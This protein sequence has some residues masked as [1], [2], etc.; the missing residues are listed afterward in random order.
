MPALSYK[1]SVQLKSRP[2]KNEI[3]H[4]MNKEPLYCLV[5]II[6]TLFAFQ[7]CTD[8]QQRSPKQK[9][10]TES[11]RK[12]KAK[13]PETLANTVETNV[14][15]KNPLDF[16]PKG[17]V[18]HTYEGGFFSEGWKEL[19]GD[20]DNDGRV[21]RV[22]IIKGTDKSKI[23]TVEYRGKLDRN[24]RGIIVLLNK[25]DY[26]ERAFKNYDCFSSENEDGGVY[27]DAE[28][29]F[30][31]KKGNVIISENHGRYGNW[32]YT[33]KL[34]RTD[35]ELIGFDEIENYGPVVLREI[36]IN[37]LSKKKLERVNVNAHVEDGKE[38]FEETWSN[39]KVEQ[40][41]KLSEINDLDELS[42]AKY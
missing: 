24:R 17:Y 30:E 33:F 1:Q 40:L 27:S 23:V 25:G 35:L 41:I 2:L 9:G 36:S 14:R 3:I 15:F 37:F 19:K 26:Y 22:L 4:Q 38:I 29:G 8:D 32:K 12:K 34:N 21:D 39:I 5:G 6:F 28:L 18:L 31:I 42:M 10:S 11:A 20:L 13:Q 7:S 16:I